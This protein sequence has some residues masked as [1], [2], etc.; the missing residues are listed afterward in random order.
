LVSGC[1]WRGVDH[2]GIVE[3][4]FE[5]TPALEN[6]LQPYIDS[7]YVH[8][9]AW[10]SDE[11]S[12]NKAYGRCFG[13]VRDTYNWVAFIDADEYIMLPN[14]WEGCDASPDMVVDC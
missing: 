1:R 4:A 11:P 13:R 8:L 10:G 14:K 2:I 9:S 12:Q 5:V 3:N 7:G 6:A